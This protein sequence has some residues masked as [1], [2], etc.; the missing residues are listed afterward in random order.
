M[1][2]LALCN[3]DVL[4][5]AKS[6]RILRILCKTSNNNSNSKVTDSTHSTSIQVHLETMEAHQ[7]CQQA[8]Q[9]ADYLVL[10]ATTRPPLI[11]AWKPDSG[12]LPDFHPEEEE[13][14]ICPT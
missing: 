10:W 12:H 14:E 3:L 8:P 4:S 9:P 2:P 1:D 13:L 6:P 11:S 7:Q 5:R